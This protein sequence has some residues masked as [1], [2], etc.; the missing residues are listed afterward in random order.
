MIDGKH[1]KSWKAF[2]QNSVTLSCE[3]PILVIWAFKEGKVQICENCQI[4]FKQYTSSF[5]L[6]YH[7]AN[8]PYHVASIY[9]STL[10]LD[11][12]TNL[13]VYIKLHACHPHMTFWALKAQRDQMITLDVNE[14]FSW[15]LGCNLTEAY[16]GAVVERRGGVCHWGFWVLR[17]ALAAKLTMSLH[18]NFLANQPWT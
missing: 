8:I 15:G 1:S 14:G 11:G 2:N 13:H 17:H 12:R 3:W 6:S 4:A 7:T 18:Q 5:H 16:R 9:Y 10:E